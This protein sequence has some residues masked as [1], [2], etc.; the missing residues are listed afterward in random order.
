MITKEIIEDNFSQ[1]NTLSYE[2]SIL[3]GVDSFDYVITDVGHQILALTS[4]AF[5]PAKATLLDQIKQELEQQHP[6]LKNRYK[7]VKVACANEKMTL[8]PSRLYNDAERITYLSQTIT[9]KAEDEIRVNDLPVLQAKNVFAIPIA[10]TE[11][12]QQ[13]F[14][15]ARIFHLCSALLTGFRQSITPSERQFRVLVH[16]KGDLLYITLFDHAHL[17]YCNSFSYKSAKDFLYYILLVFKQ[18][19]LNPEEIPLWVS[20]RLVPDSEIYRLLYRYIRHLHFVRLP[21]FYQAGPKLSEEP[22]HFYFDLLS[23]NLCV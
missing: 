16:L 20:G 13:H 6:L 9:L 18:F 22:A 12:V 1:R 23:I 15:G 5:D 14:S 8:I 11:L 10:V 19:D 17:F 21:A 4:T 7:N 2:L 3:I